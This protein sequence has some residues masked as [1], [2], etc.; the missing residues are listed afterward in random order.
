MVQATTETIGIETEHSYLS[1]HG[2]TFFFGAHVTHQAL[3]THNGKQYDRLTLSGCRGD[4]NRDYY[5][6]ITS[7]Y[8]KL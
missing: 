1:Y 7:F 2:C 6:D 8:G 3:L 4:G 5:F